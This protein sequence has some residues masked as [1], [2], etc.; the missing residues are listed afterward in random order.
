MTILS[1]LYS[2][3]PFYKPLVITLHKSD[4]F[5]RIR[6]TLTRIGVGSFSKKTMW[7]TCHILH[8]KGEYFILHFLE[9]LIKDGHPVKL[10]PEDIKRRNTVARLLEQW[11]LCS[12][13]SGLGECSDQRLRVIPFN[14]KSQWTLDSKYNTYNKDVDTEYRDQV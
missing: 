14:E 7:Q 5:L 3:I 1:P 4:D 12:V 8:E 13:V 2:V 9:M 11:G 6:E 10:S